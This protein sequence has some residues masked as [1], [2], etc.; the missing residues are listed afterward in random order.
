MK[1]HKTNYPGVFYREAERIGGKGL[2]RVY[3]IVFKKGGKVYEEKVG[4]Q[5]AD[6]MSPARA[7]RIRAERIE[8]K[9][10]SRKEIRE[11]ATE[12]KWTIGRLWEQYI[13]DKPA[14]TGFKIDRWRYKK[15][16]QSCFGEKE[17]SAIAQIDIH[18]LRITI[19]KTLSPQTVKHVL[20]LLQKIVNYGVKKGLCPGLGFKIE[21]PKVNN[22]KTE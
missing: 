10:L 3:Y 7:A 8:G 14:T 18:R 21:M 22:L 16:L 17:P 20:V 6:A 5:F 11:A 12:T 19:A 13:S 15:F 4:R 1:R 2:E 9:R